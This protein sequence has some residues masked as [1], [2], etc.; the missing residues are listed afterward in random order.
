MRGQGMKDEAPGPEINISQIRVGGGVAGLIFT[1]GSMLIFL[2]GIPVL[3]YVFAFAVAVGVGIAVVLR[4]A[5][6]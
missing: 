4:L 3:W 6:R 5:N 1:V 2:V